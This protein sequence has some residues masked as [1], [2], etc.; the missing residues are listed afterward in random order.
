MI[1]KNQILGLREANKHNL[2]AGLILNFRSY[3]NKTFFIG[4]S[5]FVSMT[6][7]L[8]KKSI[9]IQDV[10]SNNAIEIYSVKKRTR[11]KY[12]I[13]KFFEQLRLISKLDL[14]EE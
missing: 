9:N 2:T 7:R 4:I 6:E 12:D 11:Y 3:E 1:K 14:T 8:K 10:V 13:E 5:D